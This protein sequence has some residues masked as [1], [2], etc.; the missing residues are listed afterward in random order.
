[1][2]ELQGRTLSDA[3]VDAIASRLEERLASKIVHGA[4]MGALT[5]VKRLVF[6]SVLAAFAYAVSQGFR[7]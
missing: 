5:F 1:M 6:W 7:P 3:D 4:G 2:D